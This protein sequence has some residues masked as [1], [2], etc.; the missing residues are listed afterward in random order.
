MTRTEKID[1]HPFS[2]RELETIIK[3]VEARMKLTQKRNKKLRLI[4]YTIGIPI[5]FAL[6]YVFP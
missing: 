3:T 4:G 6:A 5:G 1:L 2:D